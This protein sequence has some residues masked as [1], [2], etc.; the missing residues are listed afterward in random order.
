MADLENPT[1]IKL[2]GVLF[3]IL[4]LISGGLLL[5]DRFSLT[6]LVLLAV[7]V[8][9]FCRSYYFAFYVLHHYVDPNFTYTGLTDLVR[10]LLKAKA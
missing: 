8:W 7:C 10:Y 6:A 1:V 4:G 2:K 3:L 9:A 5:A